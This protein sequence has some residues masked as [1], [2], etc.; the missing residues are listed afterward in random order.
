MLLILFAVRIPFAGFIFLDIWIYFLFR[1][2]IKF[3]TGTKFLRI[4]PIFM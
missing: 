4:A 3:S 2:I 1:E